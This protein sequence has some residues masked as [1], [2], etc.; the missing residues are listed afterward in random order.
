VQPRASHIPLAY[1]AMLGHFIGMRKSLLDSVTRS[2]PALRR[3]YFDC[4]HG[5]LHVHQAIPAGGGFD[6]KVSLLCLPAGTATGAAFGPLL[7]LLGLDRS[8]YALD[9]PGSGMSDPLGVAVDPA[10][11]AGAI[12]DFLK[13]MRIRTVDV[14]VDAASLSVLRELRLLAGPQIR[15]VVLL[16]GDDA[17]LKALRST[18]GDGQ[19]IVG[20]FRSLLAT[21]ADTEK[22][23]GT[24][25]RLFD[26][27]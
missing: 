19:H 14:L 11:G 25:R 4:R 9:L 27:G 7:S 20:E 18:G 5:Q 10:A 1:T 8:I 26:A 15:R 2:A 23:A 16:G 13:N 6:E 24:L 17:A 3:A 22:L 12:V 21:E